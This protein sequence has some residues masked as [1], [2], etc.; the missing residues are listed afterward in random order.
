VTTISTAG[1]MSGFLTAQMADGTMAMWDHDGATNR[2]LYG[3]VTPNNLLAEGVTQVNF[4]GLTANG[5]ALTTD[6]AKIHAVRCM[7]R[8]S[9]NRPTGAV[10]ETVSCIAWLRSW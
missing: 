5:L 7:V 9:L 8:Y 10:T 2:V 4:I 1:D 6:P 3:N